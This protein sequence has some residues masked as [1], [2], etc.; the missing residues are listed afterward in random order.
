MQQ[1]VESFD[2]YLVSLHKL[3]KTCNF[4]SDACTNK[5]IRDQIIEGLLDADT[6]EDLLQEIDLTL[7]RAISKC[8]TQEAAKK[9][10]AGLHNYS[11]ESV[12]ALHKPQDWKRCATT[13]TCP[14]CGAPSHP[15]GRI[16]CPAYNQT[17]FNCK[18]LS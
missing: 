7:A 17:C 2:D 3:V 8:Q 10:R 15:A 14:G 11:T 6:T 9:W 16:Q 1:T 12:A 18:S 5:N 4:C 13:S